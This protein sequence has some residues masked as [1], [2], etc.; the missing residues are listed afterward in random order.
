MVQRIVPIFVALLGVVTGHAKERFGLRGDALRP[1]S[2]DT[3]K[4][5]ILYVMLTEY[6]KLLAYLLKKAG[7]E[8]KEVAAIAGNF[9]Q[10]E[11]ELKDKLILYLWD[12]NPTRQEVLEFMAKLLTEE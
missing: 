4:K 10:E 9:E 7:L 6:Q 3:H 12:N 11:Q 8:C 5:T 1:F 2:I